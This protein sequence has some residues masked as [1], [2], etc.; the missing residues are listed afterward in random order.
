MRANPL[1]LTAVVSLGCSAGGG[2][3]FTRTIDSGTPASD[4]FVNMPVNETGAIRDAVPIADRGPMVIARDAACAT[5]SSDARRVATNLLIVLDRSGS[6]Q[7]GGKWQAAVRGLRALLGR[8]QPTTRVGLTF[9]PSTTGSADN[10]SGYV[11]P[12]VPVREMRVNQAALDGAL[13][14]ASP[15]GNTPMTCAIQGSNMFWPT[16]RDDGSRNVILITDGVPTNECTDTPGPESCFARCGT[17]FACTFSCIAE[18]DTLHGNA[19]QNAVRIAITRSG[20]LMPPVRTFV[21]GTPEASDDFLS[22][23]AV[24]G[25]TERMAGC[26]STRNCHYSLRLASFEQ[27]LQVALNDIQGRTL[28]CEFDVNTD[29]TRVDPT[30]V[31]VN[32]YPMG[33]GAAQIIPRDPNHAN[34]WD[35]GTGGRSVILHGPICDT[36]RGDGSGRVEILFGCPTIGPG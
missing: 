33:T 36:V 16:F 25:R 12:A 17:D 30:R 26:R 13:A 31:N 4:V 14:G 29:P 28:S 35:Y 24:Q 20:Q 32:Y 27:D 8:L 34:G 22:D 6:M 23:L 19:R 5:T 15:N 1:L 2:T 18:Y 7:Q 11:T 10:V 21:A 9:F 3:D